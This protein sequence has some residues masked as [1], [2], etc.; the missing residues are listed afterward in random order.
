[1]IFAGKI[2]RQA[3]RATSAVQNVLFDILHFKYFCL[4]FSLK[5][6]KK[7]RVVSGNSG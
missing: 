1:L 7:E 4:D 3:V 5:T 2:L 6:N